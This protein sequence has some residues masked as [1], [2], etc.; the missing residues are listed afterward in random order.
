MFDILGFSQEVWM[1]SGPRHDLAGGRLLAGPAYAP[2]GQ[3]YLALYAFG[4][5]AVCHKLNRVI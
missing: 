2:S 5:Q 4:S 1:L 3:L